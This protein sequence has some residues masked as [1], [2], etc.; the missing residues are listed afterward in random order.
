MEEEGVGCSLGNGGEICEIWDVDEEVETR[1]WYA[2]PGA[3]EE[4]VIPPR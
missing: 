4:M 2:L 1:W 3:M